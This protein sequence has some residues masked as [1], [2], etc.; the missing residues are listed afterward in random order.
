F[1]EKFA[2]AEDYDLWLRVGRRHSIGYIDSP[3]IQCRRHSGNTS[4][5]ITSHQ[6]FERLAL[7]KVDRFEARTAFNRL[8]PT[9]QQRAEAWTWF[10]LRRGDPEFPDESRFAIAQHPQSHPLLFALGVYQ[11]DSGQYDEALVTFQA[12]KHHDP[13]SLHN[14]GVLF[15]FRGDL[16]AASSNLE[17]AL[18]LRPD[19]YDAQYN[20]A[21][22]RDGLD[23]RLTRRPFRKHLVPMC[24]K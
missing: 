21:A 16:D 4:N 9:S 5:R 6:H 22:L 2:H 19:Y 13:A 8:Y 24:G 14:L 10:L 17:A 23:L 7:G 20:L 18:R 11:F 12:L 15:A 3:L 1:D